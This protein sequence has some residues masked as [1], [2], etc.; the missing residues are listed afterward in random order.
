MIFESVIKHELILLRILEMTVERRKNKDLE[1]KEINNKNYSLFDLYKDKV[2]FIYELKCRFKT[3]VTCF[4][5]Y[6]F[7][8]YV[9]S[10]SELSNISK[11]G[12][13][14]SKVRNYSCTDESNI[15]TH[16]VPIV[17]D[18][19]ETGPGT[20]IWTDI[21]LTLYLLARSFFISPAH[22]PSRF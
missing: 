13:L 18:Q 17:V 19:V 21:Q 7:L 20:S 11:G 3:T 9:T 14:S 6:Y 15:A 1:C 5:L 22:K 10:F 12:E 16:L 4:V 8:F 2:L